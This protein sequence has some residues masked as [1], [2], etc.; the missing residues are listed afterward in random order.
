MG[1]FALHASAHHSAEAVGGVGVAAQALQGLEQRARTLLLGRSLARST[2]NEDSSTAHH[3]AQEVTPSS[4]AAPMLVTTLAPSTPAAAI[5]TAVAGMTPTATEGGKLGFSVMS[6]VRASDS[7][8]LR[9]RLES[10]RAPLGMA[11]PVL[12]PPGWRPPTEPVPVPAPV[13]RAEDQAREGRGEGEDDLEGGRPHDEQ[14][15]S[16]K[17]SSAEAPGV[18]GTAPVPGVLASIVENVVGGVFSFASRFTPPQPP[19][20]PPPAPPPQPLVRKLFQAQALSR[21]PSQAPSQAPSRAVEAPHKAPPVAPHNEAPYR[22]P[23]VAPP[24]EAPTTIG[25]YDTFALLVFGHFPERLLI[26]GVHEL[27]G[28]LMTSD[29][30]DDDL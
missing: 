6:S 12:M 2:S 20:Q 27:D 16:T 9:Q 19:P 7:S 3:S 30:T 29:W 4:A 14:T 21:A 22:A 28:P 26:E 18:L 13:P 15:A 5:P 24:K 25:R 10:L 17:P 8:L 11:Q 1:A 23:P